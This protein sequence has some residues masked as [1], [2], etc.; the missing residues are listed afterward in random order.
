MIMA[1][2]AKRTLGIR[3]W[4]T[5]LVATGCL[6]PVAVAQDCATK[7]GALQTLEGIRAETTALYQETSTIEAN[8]E[9]ALA[10]R[11]KDSGWDTAQVEAFRRSLLESESYQVLEKARAADAENL[12]KAAAL[13]ISAA[14]DADTLTI[15]REAL[16]M[17]DAGRK[18]RKTLESQ[19]EFLRI[20]LWGNAAGA[21]APPAS[22]T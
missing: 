8:L 19:Y 11:A 15:C 12:M 17:R 21:A 16:I 6:A 22:G 7:P 2:P 9:E 3:A 4:A 5:T 18:L 20:K 13:L 1:F 10:Q 14:T